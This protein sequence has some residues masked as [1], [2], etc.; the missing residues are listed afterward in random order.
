MFGYE[1]ALGYA[2]GPLVRDKDGIGAAVHL[3]Q[4][5][6]VPQAPGPDAAG[7][8][9]RAA[10]DPRAGPPG[11][12]VGAPARA[13]G[14]RADTTRPCGPCERGPLRRLGQSPVAPRSRRGRRRGD[15]G[16]DSAD[17]SDLPRANL[18]TFQSVDGARLTARPSG[19]EPKIKFYLELVARAHTPAAVATDSGAP[20]GGRAGAAADADEEARAELKRPPEQRCRPMSEDGVHRAAL[21]AAAVVCAPGGEARPAGGPAAGRRTRPATS[22]S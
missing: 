12:V 2:V 4:P 8:D 21:V 20:R 18:V 9:R 11:P 17:P 13:R 19:T 3:A 10:R 6:P 7:A 1:E 14:P 15:R 16:R 22:S 5:R